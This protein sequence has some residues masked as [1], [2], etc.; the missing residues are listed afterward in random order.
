MLE[1]GCNPELFW[2]VHTLVLPALQQ[3][4]RQLTLDEMQVSHRFL[5][6]NKMPVRVLCAQKHLLQQPPVPQLLA[7]AEA[8][9]ALGWLQ[10]LLWQLWKWKQRREEARDGNC[11]ETLVIAA[12]LFL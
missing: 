3:E 12:L 10:A 5:S 1:R 6:T 4:P 7:L 8:G 2:G 11:A 9:L